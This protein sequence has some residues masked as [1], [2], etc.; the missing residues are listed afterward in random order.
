MPRLT[1][2]FIRELTTSQIE[3]YGS[4]VVTVYRFSGISQD[5]YGQGD[6]TYETPIDVNAHV[7]TEHDKD[8]PTPVGTRNEDGI[9]VVFSLNEL[10][11]K[12]PLISDE[13][14]RKQDVLIIRGVKYSITRTYTYGAML[15]GENVITARCQEYPDTGEGI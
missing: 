6:R 3:K 8:M 11:T 5:L 14:V 13:Y 2:Q 10:E 7:R 1:R 12:M 4:E 15:G 9:V